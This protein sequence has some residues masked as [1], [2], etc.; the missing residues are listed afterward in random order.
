MAQRSRGA[1]DLV[2][3]AWVKMSEKRRPSASVGLNVGTGRPRLFHF[4]TREEPHFL[5]HAFVMVWNVSS[6]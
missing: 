4:A 5:H 1:T 6:I 2:Y 3:C